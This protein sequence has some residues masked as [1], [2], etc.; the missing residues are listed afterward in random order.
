VDTGP[1]LRPVQYERKARPAGNAGEENQEVR[2]RNQDGS[3]RLKI[4]TKI[5]LEIVSGQPI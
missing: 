5:I 3:G 4:R 1:W 2:V